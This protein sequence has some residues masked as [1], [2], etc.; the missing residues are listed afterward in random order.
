V[1]TR[2]SHDASTSIHAE[3]QP[4]QVQQLL[5][6]LKSLQDQVGELEQ[7]LALSREQEQFLKL[8]LRRSDRSSAPSSSGQWSASS[9]QQ[10]G[11]LNAND[12]V[13]LRNVIKTMLET[14]QV[15]SLAVFSDLLKL[16][17]EEIDHINQ[18]AQSRNG[19]LSG[20]SDPLSAL[21][22]VFSSPQR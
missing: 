9:Y 15:P 4:S 8:E 11:G 6:R 17:P 16:S 18:K 7:L 20:V 5:G 1:L 3:D 19:P 12:Y 21:W 14:R 13:L 2:G 22:N 10:P